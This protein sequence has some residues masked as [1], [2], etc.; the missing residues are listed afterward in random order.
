MRQLDLF[1]TV[2]AEVVA[3]PLSRRVKVVANAAAHLAQSDAAEASRFWRELLRELVVPLVQIGLGR[4]A[5]RCEAE[6]FR[7][8]VERELDRIGPDGPPGRGLDVLTARGTR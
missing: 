1:E 2:S 8:A 4:E 3:F 6:A 5:I 7:D